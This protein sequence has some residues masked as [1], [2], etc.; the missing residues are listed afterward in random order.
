MKSATLPRPAARKKLVARPKKTTLPGASRKLAAHVAKFASPKGTRAT[1]EVGPATASFDLKK[2]CETYG[3]KQAQ[4]VQMT[5][6]SPRTVAGWA[7][8]QPLSAA[9]AQRM[10]EI[11]KLLEAM[12]SVVQPKFIGP[13]LDQPNP[14]FNGFM[15]VQLIEAGHVDQLWRMIYD[16]ASGDPG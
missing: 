7:A 3:L 2:F 10:R 16:L 13:W 6:F 8:K 5:K 11:K 14:A 1:L 12:S 15:P 4:I 9:A